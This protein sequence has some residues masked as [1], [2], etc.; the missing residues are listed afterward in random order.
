MFPTQWEVD[1]NDLSLPLIVSAC[2][3]IQP[4]DRLLMTCELLRGQ[5]KQG[6]NMSESEKFIRDNLDKFLITSFLAMSWPGTKKLKFPSRVYLFD[7][8]AELLELLCSTEPLL[9]NWT[10]SNAKSLPENICFFSSKVKYP[11]FHSITHE[12]V[13]FLIC[14]QIPRILHQYEFMPNSYGQTF[15]PRPERYFCEIDNYSPN[16]IEE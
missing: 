5:N 12:G 14:E 7:F 3:E 2:T 6:V 10:H 13:C 4:I 11:I 15:S 16:L 8:N 9:T 1:I